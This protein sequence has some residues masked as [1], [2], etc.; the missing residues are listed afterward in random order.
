MD[1]MHHNSSEVQIKRIVMWQCILMHVGCRFLIAMMYA[2]AIMWFTCHKCTCITCWW[3][4]W[5]GTGS[6]WLILFLLLLAWQQDVCLHGD[7]MCNGS[8]AR[9][10]GTLRNIVAWNAGMW[11]V[12]ACW[13]FSVR[14]ILL[15]LT[16]SG[17]KDFAFLQGRWG[18]FKIENQL[19]DFI[20]II[21]SS[22]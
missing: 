9:V 5:D 7:R 14:A 19:N 17:V 22:G 15:Q 18:I 16:I 20:V 10:T 1:L 8:E 12:R 4:G 13:V 21:L 11:S 6:G 2:H 3:W